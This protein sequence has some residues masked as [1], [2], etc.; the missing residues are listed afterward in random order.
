LDT[1]GWQWWKKG[2]NQFYELFDD[3]LSAQKIVL[4]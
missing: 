2:G 4:S 1:T 3:C